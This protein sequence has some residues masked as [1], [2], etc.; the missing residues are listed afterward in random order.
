MG[1]SGDSGF[2][3]FWSSTRCPE[4]W[5]GG[6]VEAKI[7]ALLRGTVGCASLLQ[8][9]CVLGSVAALVLC[10]G[11]HVFSSPRVFVGGQLAEAFGLVAGWGGGGGGAHQSGFTDRVPGPS[12]TVAFSIGLAGS[13]YLAGNLLLA[14]SASPVE[15]PN[16]IISTL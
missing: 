12:L 15:L 11:G 5:G 10:C 6:T 7:F 9:G 8:S 16:H 3:G 13:A 14:S 2:F 1:G 4:G